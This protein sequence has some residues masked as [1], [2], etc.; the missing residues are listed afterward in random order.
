MYIHIY[1]CTCVNMCITRVCAYVSTGAYMHID[2]SHA[3]IH[4]YTQIYRDFLVYMH[5]CTT[6]T[7]KLTLIY[8]HIYVHMYHICSYTSIHIYCVQLLYTH[9][10]AY[11]YV[12]HMFV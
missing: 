5:I 7:H 2:N 10:Y 9:K 4:M 3:H 6:C 1:R 11:Y 12:P 8:I